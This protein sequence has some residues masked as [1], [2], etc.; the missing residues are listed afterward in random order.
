MRNT[1]AES[2]QGMWKLQKKKILQTQATI[3][4]AQ[5]PFPCSL[6]L[7]FLESSITETA[8]AEYTQV[9]TKMGEGLSQSPPQ[10]GMPRR[11]IR[12]RGG[13]LSVGSLS[14]KITDVKDKPTK[15]QMYWKIESGQDEGPKRFT[16]DLWK[17]GICI[18]YITL[19]RIEVPFE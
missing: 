2:W 18:L 12:S 19:W 13:H 4:W 1:T 8:L 14:L 10:E 16:E 9:R 7:L 5:T 15:T 17:L 11:T 3:F 6:G